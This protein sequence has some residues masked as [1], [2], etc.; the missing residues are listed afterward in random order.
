MWSHYILNLLLIFNENS[1]RSQP[2]FNEQY[3]VIE[4]ILNGVIK[5][6][7]ACRVI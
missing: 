4:F 1:M 5:W 7:N 2:K 6:A 3:S